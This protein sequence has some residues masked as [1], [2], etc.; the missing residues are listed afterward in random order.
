MAWTTPGTATAGE[1]LTAAFWNQQVRDNSLMLAP[2]MAGWT[3]Y[4]ATLAAASGTPTT[5]AMNDARYIKIGRLVIISFRFTVTT[6]GTASGAATITLPSGITAANSQYQIG[7]GREVNTTGKALTLTIQTSN[8]AVNV[9]D[10]G[11]PWVANT[12]N[13]G[14]GLFE[15][16]S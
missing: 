15:A 1:V 11:T 12:V 10:N 7:A 14:T 6:V 16:T 5:A 2:F 4:T 9:Y 3:T 8:I 13:V